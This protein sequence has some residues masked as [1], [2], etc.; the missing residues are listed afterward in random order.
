M[1]KLISV[2]FKKEVL[3]ASRDKRSVMAGLLL[4]HRCTYSNVCIIYRHV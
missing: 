1:M 2:L 3:D 4:L